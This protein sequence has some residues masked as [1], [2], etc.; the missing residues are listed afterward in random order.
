MRRV[1]DL[2]GPGSK[3][4]ETLSELFPVLEVERVPGELFILMGTDLGFGGGSIAPIVGEF[5]KAQ[6]FNPAE[7]GKI[8]TVE[9]ID[10]GTDVTQV[11]RI[12]VESI[13]IGGGVGTE[14]YRDLR[15]GVGSP[16]VPST[17]VRTES[18]AVATSAAGRYQLLSNVNLIIEQRNGLFILA[19]GTGVTIGSDIVTAKLDFCFWWRERVTQPS[20]VNIP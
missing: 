20:E 7:S 4:A 10:V 12:D 19:P 1:G 18:N 17:N 16:R 9:R 15:R 14:K 2:K 11:I 8:V 3:V 13:G 5:A 6:L